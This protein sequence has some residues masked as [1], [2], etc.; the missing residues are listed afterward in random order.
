MNHKKCLLMINSSWNKHFSISVDPLLKHKDQ[1]LYQNILFFLKEKQFTSIDQESKSQGPF[2][3]LKIVLSDNLDE[4]VFV[5]K[6]TDKNLTISDVNKFQWKQ[7]PSGTNFGMV[8]EIHWIKYEFNN[9]TSK[10]IEL[11][12]CLPMEIIYS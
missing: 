12:F 1:G 6:T 9:S 2:K 8:N 11:F 4:N 10:E 7:S 3:A 5:F